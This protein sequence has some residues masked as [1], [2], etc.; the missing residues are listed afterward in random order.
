[1]LRRF[2][3]IIFAILLFSSVTAISDS[4]SYAVKDKTKINVIKSNTFLDERGY[5]NI[6]G[7]LENS[8]EEPLTVP[9]MKVK[10]LNKQSE[11]TYKLKN[12]PLIHFMNPE[13]IAPFKITIM[14]PSR[15]KQTA[16]VK[17][18]FDEK[19]PTQLVN[20]KQTKLTVENVK[21]FT[22]NS[23]GTRIEGDV[24]NNGV[25]A[26]DTFTIVI[27]F[28]DEKNHILDVKTVTHDK[29]IATGAKM[30]F[31]IDYRGSADK[32]CLIADSRYYVA[33]PAGTCE[34]TGERI[35]SK[36]S[37]DVNLPESFNDITIQQRSD[38]ARV[39][40][41]NSEQSI[42]LVK[43]KVVDA[44]KTKLR[45]IYVGQEVQ[46]QS[47]ATNNFDSAQPFTYI[48]Q[49]K[50]QDGIIVMLESNQAKLSPQEQS[51]LAVK[52]F[53]EESGK[54]SVEIFVWKNLEDP[55][56][57]TARPL[58]TSIEVKNKKV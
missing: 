55:S 4:I 9:M 17:I 1:M 33:N 24:R 58:K 22:D 14:D 46:L 2:V 36:T 13:S 23:G 16:N 53:A 29:S 38:E 51:R 47:K 52:W 34:N 54:Y 3:G 10:L 37:K 48:V 18:T 25:K 42:E 21:F 35:I 56:P 11:V 43:F 44:N 41:N 6:V 19:A 20:P 50:D 57:L 5:L 27:A 7:F 32:Y 31:S 39:Q 26:T 28:M 45:Q 40:S 30:S 12:D 15:S 8:G 49:I